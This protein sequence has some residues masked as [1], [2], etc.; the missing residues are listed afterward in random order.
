MTIVNFYPQRCTK[1]YT[2]SKTG[3][4]IINGCDTEENKMT[5]MQFVTGV[6]FPLKTFSIVKDVQEDYQKLAN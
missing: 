3:Q 4:Y 5:C 1:K 6:D 2:N